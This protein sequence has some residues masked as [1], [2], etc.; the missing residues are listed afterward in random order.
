MVINTNR[1]TLSLS[2]K[3]HLKVIALL[4]ISDS[5][6]RKYVKNLDR[7]IGNLCSM[8]LA[9]LGAIGHFYVMQVAL[10]HTR[11]KKIP[12]ANLSARF[13]QDIKLWRNLCSDMTDLPTYLADLVHWTSSEFSHANTLGLGSGGGMY[14]P[15]QRHQEIHLAHQV[16]SQHHPG[17]GQLY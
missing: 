16:T 10:T 4:E 6:R 17:A 14:R 3:K 8:Y 7:L 15:Q 12:A 9:V 1:V 11:S 13:H 2:S 5:Q